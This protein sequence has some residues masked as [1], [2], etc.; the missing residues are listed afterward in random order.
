MELHLT[1]R[2]QKFF[3][4]YTGTVFPYPTSDYTKYEY[5]GQTVAPNCSSS[6]HRPESV[7]RDLFFLL[8]GLTSMY[9][10]EI[11][12]HYWRDQWLV[13]KTSIGELNIND[14]YIEID[15]EPMYNV[16]FQSPCPPLDDNTKVLHHLKGALI[17]LQHEFTL[18]WYEEF[19]EDS[20]FVGV[21]SV[22]LSM[23]PHDWIPFQCA[24][25][26]HSNFQVQPPIDHVPDGPFTVTLIKT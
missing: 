17:T 19:L 11:T 15:H 25:K 3:D 24:L 7:T 13:M 22:T 1:P 9:N 8:S 18:Y 6:H 26:E 20:T 5:L 16:L 2:V 14:S 4:W 21:N 23:T 10:V 12:E